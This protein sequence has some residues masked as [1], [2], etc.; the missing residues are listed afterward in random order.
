MGNLDYALVAGISCYPALT[1]LCGSVND[2]R[3]FSDW[4]LSPTGGCLPPANVKLVLSPDP[5]PRMQR[6]NAIPTQDQIIQGF[7]EILEAE[8]PDGTIGRRLYVYLAGHGFAPEVDD[9]A[10]L[11][12]NASNKFL[13]YIP[14]RPYAQWFHK[15]A[16]FEEIVLFMDC[17]RDD[18]AAPPPHVPPW[19]EEH[20]PFAAK[21]RRFYVFAT[22]IY[23]SARER[24]FPASGKVRG[25][26][27][28]ALLAAL[29]M[30][31]PDQDG[32]IWGAALKKYIYNYMRE[33][34]SNGKY[35]EP[36][37][38]FD[39]DHD[40][41][42]VKTERAGQLPLIID[43]AAITPETVTVL[44]KDFTPVYEGPAKNNKIELRLSPGL[45]LIQESGTGKHKQ[46]DVIQ[47]PEGEIHVSF[48]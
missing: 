34:C 46:V 6:R 13:H 28:T 32:V 48:P 44:A 43:F 3:G 37:F 20:S 47:S 24:T 45:Y 14:G 2:A 29:G 19:A 17:C 40:I 25:V 16:K 38:D 4:L 26:F 8:R 21:V 30:A 36:E 15:A 18:Y 33:L 10:L 5:L 23:R 9:A 1:D 22:Q 35:Q 27:T 39:P 42:F 11:M 31:E 41:A 7:E 12:A